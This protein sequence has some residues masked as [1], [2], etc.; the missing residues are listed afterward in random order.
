MTFIVILRQA[1]YLSVGICLLINQFI[2][3]YIV[4]DTFLVSK[5]AKCETQFLSHAVDLNIPGSYI[6]SC[7][8]SSSSQGDSGA[9][10]YLL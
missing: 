6:F 10:V 7:I 1:I 8:C 3:N 5:R 9:G 2:D 4:K